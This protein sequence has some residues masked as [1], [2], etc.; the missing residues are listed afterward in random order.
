MTTLALSQPNSTTVRVKVPTAAKIIF[1][2]AQAAGTPIAAALLEKFFLTPR[3]APISPEET[4]FLASGRSDR[5]SVGGHELATWS[6]GEGRTA[7]LVHGWGSRAARFRTLAPAL[8]NAGYRVVAFDA[9]GHGLSSGRMSSLPETARAI[10]SLARRER[11]KRG[12]LPALVVA[13]S[14]GAAATVMAQQQAPIARSVFLAPATDF[15]AYVARLAGAL[16]IRAEVIA[17]MIRRVERRL[18]FSW[19]TIRIGEIARARNGAAMIVHDPADPEVPFGDAQLLASAWRNSELVRVQDLGHR[20]LL[21]DPAVIER[22][23][24]FAARGSA[25]QGSTS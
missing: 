11:E 2:A 4:A 1:A 25:S 9:P 21:H 24:T 10:A 7:L 19:E 6:W 5:L 12:A 15:D 14:F 20:R 8:V 23:V 18:A 22:I 3:R 16:D 17:A 13:H